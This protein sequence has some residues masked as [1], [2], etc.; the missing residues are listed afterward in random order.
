[1][2]RDLTEIDEL[3]IWPMRPLLDDIH[4]KPITSADQWFAQTDEIRTRFLATTGQRPE[5]QYLRGFE[6]EKAELDRGV[7]R[8]LVRIMV[9]EDDVMEAWL[10]EPH[11]AQPNGGAALALHPTTEF[12][13]NNAAGLEGDLSWSYGL[14][15]AQRGWVVLAPDQLAVCRRFAKGLKAYDTQRFY[16]RFPDWSAVGKVILDGQVALDVM[17]QLPATKD[18][19]VSLIGH[20]LGGHSSVFLAAVDERPRQIVCNCGVIPFADSQMRKQ[21]FRD[22]WYIYFKDEMLKKS[23]LEGPRPIWDF[24]ELAALIAPRRQWYAFAMNDE[25]GYSFVSHGWFNEQ[26]HRVYQLVGADGACSI[27]NHNEKH[28]FNSWHREFAYAWLEAGIDY[29]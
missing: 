1:M 4:G 9:D 10:L 8:S 15:L 16:E 3:D 14:H 20:S 22:E 24:H 5:S 11:D 28:I 19:P 21:W 6:V 26:V 17:G 18:K 2:Q 23:V 25:C 29:A 7:K 12:G 13:K 27:L